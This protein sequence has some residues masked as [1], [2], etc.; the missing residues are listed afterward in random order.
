MRTTERLS[1]MQLEL[2]NMF[3]YDLSDSQLK[4][5]KTL[6]SN[7]FAEQVSDQIDDFFE[8]NNLGEETIEEWSKEH[9][10]RKGA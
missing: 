4:D 5:V 1:N 8:K 7:Y 2:I 10:R 6:L 3:N 9:M